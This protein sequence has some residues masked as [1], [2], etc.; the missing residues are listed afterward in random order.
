MAYEDF[1]KLSHVQLAAYLRLLRITQLPK[2]LGA[3]AVYSGVLMHKYPAKRQV[4][5]NV[6]QVFQLCLF[7]M[8]FVHMSACVNLF[9]GTSSDSWIELD[10]E[11]RP[12]G[13]KAPVELYVD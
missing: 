2:I 1:I 7:L 6:K 8:L 13:D 9:Q 3:T 10:S 4:I 12:T 11:G 5:F